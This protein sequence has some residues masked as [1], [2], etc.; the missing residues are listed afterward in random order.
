MGTP[1]LDN[2]RRLDAQTSSETNI[3]GVDRNANFKGKLLQLRGTRHQTPG[4]N[5]AVAIAEYLYERH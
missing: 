3:G 1:Q 5:H 2:R 4:K